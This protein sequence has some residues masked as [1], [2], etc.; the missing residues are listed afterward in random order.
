MA[1]LGRRCIDCGHMIPPYTTQNVPWC[2]HERTFETDLNHGYYVFK[3]GEIPLGREER[4][5]VAVWQCHKV[6]D[7]VKVYATF[8]YC[9]GVNDLSNHEIF[10]DGGIENC[11]THPS[12]G[13][14]TFM[15]LR[16]WDGGPRQAVWVD[17]DYE[18]E[19]DNDDDDDEYNGGDD[20]EE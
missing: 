19:D 8:I 4:K 12:C 9:G 5:K 11:V 6:G 20:E 15:V 17:G 10:A 1:K 2:P 14:H 16:G 3:K 7:K 18:G 13:N